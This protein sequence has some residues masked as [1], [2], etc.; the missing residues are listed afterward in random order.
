MGDNLDNTMTKSMTLPAG[1]TISADVWY[2]TEAHFDYAFLEVSTDNGANW[3]PIKTSLSLPASDD[4]GQFNT[5]GTGFAGSS[6][7][8]Y[9]PMVTT[10]PLPTG[11]VQVRFRYRTDQNT[12]GKGVVFDNIAVTGSPVDGAETDTGWT[13]DGFSRMEN[14]VGVTLKFNA[15]VAEN[16]GYRSYDTSLKTAYNFGF[17]DSRPD[18]VESYAYQDGLLISYWDTSFTNNNVGDHPG[19]GLILP[20]DAHPTFHHAQDGTLLR[21]RIL[22]FDSTFSKQDTKAITVNINSKPT[23]IPAQKGVDTFDDTKDYWFATENGHATPHPGR[24]QPGWNSV[25]VPKTGTTIS[26]K[27]GGPQSATMEVEVG[28][29]K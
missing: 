13:F 26:I 24:Y 11:S 20:V 8:A 12:G 17:L 15:Y 9:V 1:A 3:T 19:G 6:G 21:P 16:R 27:S 18:W 25:K 5:S 28:T 4:Q 2:D 22:S 10:V 7:G 29:S 14:G 23:T